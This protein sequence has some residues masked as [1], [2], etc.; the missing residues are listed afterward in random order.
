[1]HTPGAEV[2]GFIG[3]LIVQVT[4]LIVYGIFVRYDYEMLPNGGKNDN[5]TYDESFERNI[6]RE[7]RASY[8][9]KS[10]YK[11]FTMTVLAFL[12]SKSIC[13]AIHVPILL[14]C[15]RIEAIAYENEMNP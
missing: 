13:I 12:Q 3:I 5:T 8:P 7:H 1:M 11:Q 9:R 14:M 4:I 2:S 10:I 6:A 15:I